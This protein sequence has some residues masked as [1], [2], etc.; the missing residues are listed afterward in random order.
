M[1]T[2]LSILNFQHNS[3]IDHDGISNLIGLTE[4]KVN[5]LITDEG[6]KKL[7]SLTYLNV[8]NNDIIS[9]YGIY[10]LTNL[11]TILGRCFVTQF[12]R[13][14][15]S[16]LTRLSGLFPSTLW[17]I[18]NKVNVIISPKFPRLHLPITKY[19]D[20]IMNLLL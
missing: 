17:K 5:S 14:G 4:I 18:I 12:T 10:N 11:Q 7:T 20:Q 15:I 2:L 3:Q 6:I 9:D 8:D 1:L 13:N 19:Y 16:H